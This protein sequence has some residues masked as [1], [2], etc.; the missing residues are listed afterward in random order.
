MTSL[1]QPKETN[2]DILPPERD[3][4]YD[5]AVSKGMASNNQDRGP[6]TIGGANRNDSYKRAKGGVNNMR[7]YNS[8]PRLGKDKQ[9]SAAISQQHYNNGSGNDPETRSLGDQR[10]ANRQH[11]RGGQRGND[12]CQMM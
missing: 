12:N 3:S 10:L 5:Q 9:R 7:N 8:L 4:E 6:S 2:T 1:N 11:R